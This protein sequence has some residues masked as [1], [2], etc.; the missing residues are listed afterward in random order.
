MTLHLLFAEN[1]RRKSAEFGTI[2]D[3]CRGIGVNRQ[4]FNKYLA[5]AAIPN[6]ITLRKICQFLGIQ[7]RELFLENETSENPLAVPPVMPRRG[8]LGFFQFAANHFDFEV[9]DLQVGLYECIM[10]LVEVPGMLMKSLL[11]IQQTSR[12]KEF[13][14]LTKVTTS[15]NQPKLIIRGRHKG[16]VFAS[17]SDIYLLGVNRYP[18]FQVSFMVLKRNDGTMVGLNKGSIMTQS[19]NGPISSRVCLVLAQQQGNLKQH[20]R[21]VGVQHI[22]AVNIDQLALD[23]LYS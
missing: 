21:D 7:E 11:L 14:R 13:V 22:S 5:G 8:P 23:F 9:N 20:I 1:L 3:V 12:Q 6:A 16:V 10:P 15:K 19:L 17:G 2:A 18:P 4:Q